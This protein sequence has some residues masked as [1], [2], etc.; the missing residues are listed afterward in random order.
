[1]FSD[2]VVYDDIDARVRRTPCSPRTHRAADTVLFVSVRDR[3]QDRR[4]K[5]QR[6]DRRG[7]IEKVLPPALPRLFTTP[8]SS[9]QGRTGDKAET[10]ALGAFGVIA[11][12]ATL[13]IAAR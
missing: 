6:S 11:A 8:P 13:V 1:V 12:L 5:P 2:T 3:T 4:W 9:R 10:I 7:E